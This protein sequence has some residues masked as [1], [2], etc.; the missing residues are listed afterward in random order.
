MAKTKEKPAKEKADNKAE[1]AA[2]RE[3]KYGVADLAEKLGI[4]PASVRVQL[5][6]KGIEKAGKSYGW[7]TKGELEE[8]VTQLRAE[9]PAKKAK[10]ADEKPAAKA[11]DK[12]KPAKTGKKA[13][14]ADNDD[15]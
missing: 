11:K 10:A 8:V 7:N 15:D 12:A 9:K 3:F 14:P 13:K 1:K 6:S 5:R 4:E 2:E